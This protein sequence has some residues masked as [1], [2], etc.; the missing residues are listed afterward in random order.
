MADH[1]ITP[2]EVARTQQS[3]QQDLRELRKEAIGRAEYE[4]DQ[5]GIDRRF[6]ESANVHTQLDTKVTV[7]DTKNTAKIEAVDAKHTAENLAVREK[8][9]AYDK[10]QRAGRSKWVLAM[11]TAVVASV[12]SLLGSV[13]IQGGV[14]G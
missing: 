12:L 4:A 8:L 13:L 2:A 14:G 11:V 7:V 6:L 10:E 9:E 5:E 3:L 1:E